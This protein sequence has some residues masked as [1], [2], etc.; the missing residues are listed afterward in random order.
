M[1]ASLEVQHGRERA[2]TGRRTLAATIAVLALV[3][4]T[5][6]PAPASAGPT[7][8]GISVF[9]AGSATRLVGFTRVNC[10]VVSLTR[11]GRVF[12]RDLV[13][14]ATSGPWRLGA[15]VGPFRGRGSYAIPRQDQGPDDT[16]F[17]LRGPT[18]T[19]N[20]LSRP[21]GAILP[22]TGGHIT[23]DGSRPLHV[24]LGYVN[25]WNLN[26]SAA[27]TIGGVAHCV[28]PRR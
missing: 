25:A 5:S 27:V 24:G 26:L 14:T 22:P 10:R 18:G 17:S 2:R 23:T 11:A 9:D 8:P 15:E 20:N 1:I 19:Y 4:P 6:W 16:Y 28:Y 3:A 12:E 21:A 7:V 13:I